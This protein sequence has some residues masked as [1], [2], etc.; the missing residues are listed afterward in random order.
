MTDGPGV[1]AWTLPRYY[2]F[3]MNLPDPSDTY[4]TQRVR[5]AVTAIQTELVRRKFLYADV[6]KLDG[7][8]GGKT[9]LS[10][11][12][13]QRACGLTP[14]G[15]VGPLTAAKL[16][17][18]FFA[19]W[20]ISLVIPDNYLAG[21]CKLESGFDPGAEGR[22][23]NRDRGVFQFN[24]LYH[25]DITDKIAYSDPPFCIARAASMLRSA[26]DSLGSW[27]AALANHN[28]PA[29][30][31]LWAATGVAP[32]AQIKTYVKLVKTASASYS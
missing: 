29:K 2:G 16:W 26:F 15:K 7:R 1:G 13:F 27:D 11:Q 6:S 8:I 3:G 32:D 12:Q 28:N 19:W 24:R 4:Q 9:D 5:W 21:L 23:D 20:Q 31:K 25:P 22:V 14:D 10:I 18:Q 30:A 17:S